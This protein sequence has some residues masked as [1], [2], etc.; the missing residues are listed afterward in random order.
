MVNCKWCNDPINYDPQQ[1]N[2]VFCNLSHSNKFRYQKKIDIYNLNPNRCLQC[3]ND[4]HYGKK[5]QKFCSMSC[6]AIYNNKKR[7]PISDATRE[8][9]SKSIKFWHEKNITKKSKKVISKLFTCHL[10]GNIFESKTLRKTCSPECFHI[11]MVNA[12]KSSASK[13]VKR[14]KDEIKLFNLCCNHFHNVNNNTVIVDGWDADIILNDQKIA[15]LWNGPWHYQQMPLSRHSLSQVQNRDRIKID[16]LTKAG[17]QVVVF[18]DRNY[19]PE[20]AFQYL[21]EMVAGVGNALHA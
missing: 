1:P 8:K 20:S 14:S 10:C 4:L 15:I 13:M 6:S 11:A 21:K 16:I 17:W 12:G 3:K 19:T 9:R 7:L 2:K 5:K 18:E